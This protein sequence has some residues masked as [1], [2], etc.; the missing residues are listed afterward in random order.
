MLVVA[1]E[2]AE[3][4]VTS[5]SASGTQP[6]TVWVGGWGNAAGRAPFQLQ[7]SAGLVTNALFPTTRTIAQLSVTV[8]LM[9]IA[10]A[11]VCVILTGFC[12]FLPLLDM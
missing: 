2:T 9:C 1:G 11:S 6:V 10:C 3:F 7:A 12:L 5:A 8:R 4:N